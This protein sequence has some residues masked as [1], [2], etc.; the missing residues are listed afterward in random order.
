MPYATR[1]DIE[2]IF[3]IENVQTWGNMEA[4]DVQDAGVLTAIANRITRAITHADDMINAMLSGSD[5]EIPLNAKPSK[6]I[7]LITTASAELAG[8]WLYEARGLDN[9]DDEGRPYN[10]YSAKRKAALQMI[11]DIADGSIKIDAV[12]GTTGVNVPF[13]V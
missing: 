9:K 1:T 12:A 11:K 10:R 3:G 8:C 7:G 2:D 4:G 5:Y 13:V 6:S